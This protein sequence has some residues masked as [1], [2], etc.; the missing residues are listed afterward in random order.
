MVF[1]DEELRGSVVIHVKILN[2]VVVEW[3]KIGLGPN[4]QLCYVSRTNLTSCGE[5]DVKLVV[6]DIFAKSVM[7]PEMASCGHPTR[8]QFAFMHGRGI[9]TVQ[10]LLTNKTHSD[11]V[12]SN[13]TNIPYVYDPIYLTKTSIALLKE[14]RDHYDE[15]GNFDD[16][17]LVVIMDRKKSRRL[18]QRVPVAK[19][20]M[21]WCKRHGYAVYVFGDHMPGISPTVA[22]Q[23]VIFNAA[24]IVIGA[25]GGSETNAISMRPLQSCLIEMYPTLRFG[26]G[27]RGCYAPMAKSL[28]IHFYQIDYR[29]LEIR[30]SF[31]IIDSTMDACLEEVSPGSRSNGF[32]RR[33][34]IVMKADTAD[35]VGK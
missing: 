32:A 30:S 3:L 12:L 23:L 15:H 8:E 33:E 11:I 1:S 9:E 21:D 20:I 4:T 25:H 26:L 6:G 14:I 31:N 24:T 18:K 28:S 10:Y 34:E 16:Y 19:K 7:V 13:L 27:I 29:K 17:K 2:A 22:H 35:T 5:G